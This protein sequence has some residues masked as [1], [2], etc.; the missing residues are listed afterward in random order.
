MKP[1]HSHHIFDI[2]HLINSSSVGSSKK[3]STP[4]YNAPFTKISD[5][6]SH[7]RNITNENSSTDTLVPASKR[8]KTTHTV[9]E[10]EEEDEEEVE[11]K[12][13]DEEE[14]NE[15][16]TLVPTQR[17]SDAGA[18]KPSKCSYSIDSILSSSTSFKRSVDSL[19]N[20][21][22]GYNSGD[23]GAS[24]KKNKTRVA[25][26]SP[27]DLSL[28]AHLGSGECANSSNNNRQ[29]ADSSSSSRSSSSSLFSDNLST[30]NSKTNTTTNDT[31]EN[32]CLDAASKTNPEE[33]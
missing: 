8:L 20:D 19:N 25:L 21:E 11:K 18:V 29:R 6:E 2:R 26:K 22:D 13:D 9:K 17:Q 33:L 10:N 27:L 24:T 3:S 7:K 1:D 28:G 12:E 16:E 32:K 5:S 23:S 31:S 30:S 14:E 15:H 4:P